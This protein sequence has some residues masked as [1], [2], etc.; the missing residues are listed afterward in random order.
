MRLIALLSLLPSLA[1]ADVVVSGTARPV[2][3]DGGVPTVSI[4][5]AGGQTAYTTYEGRLVTSEEQLISVDEVEGAV[6]DY[7][8]WIPTVTT[9]TTGQTGNILSNNAGIL[10]S[11]GSSQITSVTSY[12][13]FDQAYVLGTARA[14]FTACAQANVVCEMGFGTAS[15]STGPTE[16]VGIRISGAGNAQCVSVVNSVETVTNLSAIPTS[17]SFYGV[18]IRWNVDKVECQLLDGV[19][20]TITGVVDVPASS[21]GSVGVQRKPFYFRTYKTATGGVAPLTEISS[22]AVYRQGNEG[23]IPFHTL[24]AADGEDTGRTPVAV[25][26]L[27][28]PLSNACNLTNAAATAPRVRTTVGGACGAIASC[29][30]SNTAGCYGTT[31]LGGWFQHAAVACPSAIA[32]CGEWIAFGYQVPTGRQLVITG[33]D[34]ECQNEVAAVA[35]TATAYLFMLATNS[36]GVSLAT[37]V[38]TATVREYEKLTLGS[39]N[40]PIGTANGAPAANGIHI[41]LSGRPKVVAPG[42]FASI[43]VRQQ[44]G[45]ATA[46]EL[47]QCHVAVSGYF[48]N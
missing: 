26:S 47:F 40:F 32:S 44:I 41:D 37:E 23:N 13:P 31:L 34:I 9:W 38:E 3:A 27:F 33:A 11:I 43:V 19:T 48:K 17:G 12:N 5:G 20:Q 46:T 29:T 45:T 16:F 36:S 18:E 15:G 6:I 22:W 24:R 42:R 1:L 25:A 4:A 39:I 2:S 14:K 21:L 10:T 30:A 7:R 8:K 35:T 28:A